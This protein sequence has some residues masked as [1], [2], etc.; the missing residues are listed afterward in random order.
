MK[1]SKIILLILAVLLSFI[2]VF[3]QP[4]MLALPL[5]LFLYVF[6]YKIIDA[7]KNT[8][9][10]LAYILV[11]WFLGMT[12]ELL[13]IW[14]NMSLPFGQR[15]LFN[16]DP[17]LDL[18][19]GAG[20]YFV[21]S[22]ILYLF[23]QRYKFSKKIFL[24]ITA[25]YAIVIEQLGVVFFAGLTNPLL[26]VY[27]AIVYGVWTVTPYLLFYDRFSERRSPSFWVYFMLLIVLWVASF[28]GSVLGTLL[29]RM[30]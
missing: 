20:F 26:W 30:I 6:R 13:A 10:S 18:M 28:I 25:F 9:L 17:I 12:I 3:N 19:V 15:K 21:V 16:Q 27:V 24:G 11:G 1:L 5:G 22:I 29:S 14:Q 8:N 4:Q 23:V 7:F 2:F